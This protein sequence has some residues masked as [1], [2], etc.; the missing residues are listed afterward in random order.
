VLEVWARLALD[1]DLA[2]GDPLEAGLL[3]GSAR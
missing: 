3:A 2:P 1:R